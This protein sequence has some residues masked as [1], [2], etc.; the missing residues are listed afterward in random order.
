VESALDRSLREGVHA[1]A[2][3]LD[4]IDQHDGLPTAVDVVH[5]TSRPWVLRRELLVREGQP[6]RGVAESGFDHLSPKQAVGGGLRIVFP[7]IDRAVRRLDVGVP[8]V[9]GVRPADV[10]PVA[11]HQALPLPSPG[12]GL[13]P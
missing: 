11:F 9:S 4:P 2:V 1:R 10:P 12:A 6:W 13:G 8:M 7:Q 5:T 3:R